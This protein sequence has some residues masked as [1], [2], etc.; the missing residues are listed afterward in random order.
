MELGIITRRSATGEPT[1]LTNQVAPRGSLVA[2]AEQLDRMLN[3]E[4]RELEDSLITRGLLPEGSEGKGQAHPRG[5]VMLWHATGVGLRSIA[6]EHDFGGIRERRWLWEAIYNL[7][8]SPGIKRAERGRNRN[9]FEY[10]FR[11]G[12]IPLPLAE[13]IRW[14]EWVYFFDSTTIRGETRADEWLQ[15]V[16]A[17]REPITRSQ[18]RKFSEKLNNRIRLLD[19]SVLSR[20]ELYA[21]YDE[22]WASAKREISGG[23]ARDGDS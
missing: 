2:Q 7:H 9:H 10:C 22:A 8:A 1:I 14:S 4:V 11:L 21:L 16:L 6:E 23:T 20:K 3:A 17:R 5:D 18:F 15:T 12:K 13:R 19:T